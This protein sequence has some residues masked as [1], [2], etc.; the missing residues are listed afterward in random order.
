MEHRI[1]SIGPVTLD[2]RRLAGSDLERDLRR[3]LN[4]SSTTNAIHAALAAAQRT[5]DRA[6]ARSSIRA[7]A[8]GQGELRRIAQLEGI[9]ANLECGLAIDCEFLAELE[10]REGI[11]AA[12]VGG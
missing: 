7:G 3:S 12:I 4:A 9:R 2:E 11:V 6:E 5:G 1:Y 10:I 8:V